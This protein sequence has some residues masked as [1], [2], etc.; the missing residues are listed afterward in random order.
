MR[1]DDGEHVAAIERLAEPGEESGIAEGAPIEAADDGDTVPNEGMEDELE[2]EGEDEGEADDDLA[3]DAGEPTSRRDES[4]RRVGALA[5]DRGRA[6]GYVRPACRSNAASRSSSAPRRSSPA[7]STRRCARAAPSAAIRVFVAQGDGAAIYGRRRQPLP[8][9]DRQ[10]GPADPRPRHPRDPR[11]DRGDDGDGHHV[12]RAD[13]DRGPVRRGAARARPVDGDGA[14]GVVGHRGDDERAAPRARLHRPRR[15]SSRPTAATTATPTACSSRPARAPRRSASPARPASPRARRA[16]RSSC[17]TTTSPRSRQAFA[18]PAT[19]PRSSSSR[20]PATWAA[21]RPRRAT[22][23]ACARSR[24]KHGTLLIF[25]EV[26][27][28]FRVAYGGA[29]ARY[30]ITPGPHLDRQDHRRRPAGR[31]VRRPR[32]HHAEARAARA[33]STRPAR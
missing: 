30:G 20:S 26:M 28:G 10:L 32:R 14:R 31:G 8:R 6:P 12:R 29:Q 9:P 17:R 7:A 25:D 18:R 33:R 1:V 27:T 13:R 5:S 4:A 2:D 21:S 16:T 11:R 19:S 3:D 24:S 15:R 23:R 22:S